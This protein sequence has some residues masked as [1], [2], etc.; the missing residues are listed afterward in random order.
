MKKIFCLIVCCLL[1][2]SCGS[3]KKEDKAVVQS[4]TCS[5]MKELVKDGAVLVDVRTLAEYKSG[6]LDEAVN[7]PVETIADT[8][9]NE[10]SDKDT[11]IV[12]Y[13]R[14]GNRS[15]TAKDVLTNLGYKNVYDLGAMSNCF[16]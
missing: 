16:N 11:K 2:C 14:S 10:I 8:I 5:E 7:L 12:L 6:H 1:L 15:A 4:V 13:C 9:G 3:D